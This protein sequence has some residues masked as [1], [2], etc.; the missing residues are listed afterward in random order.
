M[1]NKLSGLDT[2]QRN[3]NTMN[4]DQLS[5]REIV[6]KI[7]NEDH[8]VP[9]AIALELDDIAKLIEAA[10]DAYSKGGRI[11]Y[12][13]AGTS[14]RLGILD[15]SECP[16]TFG[17]SHD[18]FIA[19]IAG[20]RNAMFKAVEGA[21]DSKEFGVN[22]LKEINLTSK[23]FVI[24]LAASGRTPYV[25]GAVEYANEV[26]CGTGSIDC[27]KDSPLAKVAKH[28]VEVHVGP[29][30]LTGSTRLKA[31][32]AQKLV[33][34]MVSTTIMIKA[35][36]VYENLMVDVKTSNEKLVDRA[37]RIVSEVVDCNYETASELLTKS[38]MDVKTA[39]L[40]G[41]TGCENEDC[42]DLLLNNNGNIAKTI[43]QSK[44]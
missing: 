1:K 2:E 6:E 19:L 9:E 16:P 11:V 36:K 13:G 43:R 17:V 35:G 41:I 37:T 21:E 23:D 34:N 12:I 30:A 14:G 38:N 29:E 28:P 25:I 10:S 44:K 22:D 33:L 3:Q 26:G 39:I 27:A 8:K 4:L 15:A 24:G 31:G 5:A 32:T 18:D 40:K 7:N 20:G 42:Q